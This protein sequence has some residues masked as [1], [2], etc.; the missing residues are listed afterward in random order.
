[1]MIFL[2]ERR[3]LF[4]LLELQVIKRVISETVPFLPQ[5]P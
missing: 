4:L 3:I 5:L 2:K 1:V